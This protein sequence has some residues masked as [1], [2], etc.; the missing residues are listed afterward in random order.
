MKPRV[1]NTINIPK[2][3]SY[4]LWLLAVLT[5]VKLAILLWSVDKGLE[6]TDEGFYMLWFNSEHLY[7]PD[8]HL[9]FYYL[10]QLF[11]SWID[12]TVT[13]MRIAGI[14][15]D[16]GAVVAIVWGVAHFIQGRLPQ[17]YS[18]K[19][20]TVLAIGGF[21]VLFMAENP[22]MLSYYS[23]THLLVGTGTG[24]LLYWLSREQSAKPWQTLAFF[25][26]LG[27]ILACQFVVK[28]SS[29]ILLTGLWL[30]L[31]LIDR[32]PRSRY[33]L[34]SAGAI[35]GFV[36]LFCLLFIF[37]L[38]P[39]EMVTVVKDG[40]NRIAP[41][42][43]SPIK[44]ILQKY[45][46]ADLVNFAINTLPAFLSMM[47]S[48]AVLKASNTVKRISLSLGVALFVFVLQQ[49]L[50]PTSYF[51]AWY[52]RW[53]D[54]SLLLI[55]SGTYLLW[56][57]TKAPR[58]MYIMSFALFCLPF[59]CA[60]GSA[61]NFALMLM[62]YQASWLI[63]ILLQWAYL[64]QELGI[65]V[66]STAIRYTMILMGFGIFAHVF[67]W[68]NYLPNGIAAPLYEQTERVAE[69]DAVKMDPP[70]ANF[71]NQTRQMLVSN[72]FKPGNFILAM[73]DLP[74]L[75]YLL[76]GNSPKISWYYG[77]GIRDTKKESLTYTCK[78]IGEMAFV[79]H[80]Y[81]VRPKTINPQVEAC[82]R[83][84]ALGFPEKYILAGTVF[85]PYYKYETEIWVP[86]M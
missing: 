28:F 23:V 84:S 72:G 38:S 79:E 35:I 36:A 85:N 9:N 4:G 18:P 46:Q 40:Y 32:K 61:V 8:L 10:I 81:I 56:R 2:V 73:Y 17:L 41:L 55:L 52:F 50:F 68:P 71:V 34:S 78:Y 27:A 21:S 76:Q 15:A 70:T 64:K 11:F 80:I 24:M 86:K 53:I 60:I 75:V 16:V 74:A 69:H 54:V 48:L 42:G 37:Q 6:M 13:A 26:G 31:P 51:S 1:S 14:V 65:A 44:I 63:L 20:F 62:P 33:L 45:I 43:Y 57:F 25:A 49:W 67:I 77:E 30:A 66:V 5:L 82:L 12:W 39:A 58:S 83:A 59:F 29:S 22:R 3:T 19:L 47:V 7:S